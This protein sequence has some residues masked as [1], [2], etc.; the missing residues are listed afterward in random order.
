MESTMFVVT[1]KYFSCNFISRPA[2][3]AKTVL[4]G[5]DVGL[6]PISYTWLTKDKVVEA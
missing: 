4:A 5:Y 2:Q 1:G 3:T 6:N